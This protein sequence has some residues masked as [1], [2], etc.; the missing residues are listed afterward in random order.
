MRAGPAAAVI[1]TSLGLSA[2]CASAGERAGE[3]F[4]LIMPGETETFQRAIAGE[5]EALEADMAGDES[6]ESLQ[7]NGALNPPFRLDMDEGVSCMSIKL[8]GTL[9]RERV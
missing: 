7:L 9:A 2:I 3:T 6:F 8:K 4:E 5:A 1:V